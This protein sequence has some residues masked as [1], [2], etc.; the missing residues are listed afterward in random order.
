MKKKIVILLLAAVMACSAAACGREVVP[1]NYEDLENTEK[2]AGDETDADETDTDETDAAKPEEE[3]K[4]VSGVVLGGDFEEDYDGFEYLYCDTLM[5]EATEN[6]STGKMES[7]KLKIFLPIADYTSVN[8]D[9]AYVDKLGVELEVAL[10][11]YLRYDSEDY[12]MEENL[13]YFLESE[14]DEFYSTNYRDIA[15]SEVESTEH[16]VRAV[17]SYCYYDKWNDSYLP[18]YCT[19]YLTELSKDLQVMVEVK[20]TL[21]DTTGKTAAL[22]AELESF[23]DFDIEWDE[24]A[25]QAKLDAFLASE[26]AD[27]NMVS[28]GFLVF[29]LPKDWEQDYDYGD[30]HSYAY[31]PDGDSS[32]AGCVI[33]IR[34]EYLG[35]DSFDMTKVLESQEEMDKYAAYLMEEMGAAVSDMEVSDYG[36][37]CLGNTMKISYTTKDGSYEDRTEWYLTV[38]DSYAYSV[39]AVALPDCTEDVFTIAEDILANGKA[40]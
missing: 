30:Y 27:K 4:V 22:L 26:E 28:T 16:G 13:Q 6:T 29:E 5:T 11:P 34:R 37:T 19:Y 1:T 15:L 14:F 9:R 39:M 32:Y 24:E 31:A 21:E 7:Q 35:Y 38:D 2:P 8:R 40:K 33:N 36:V 3:K 12:T 18:I 20:I 17:A 23:Y 25:A 10:N